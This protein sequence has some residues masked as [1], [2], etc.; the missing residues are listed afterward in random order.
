[1]SMLRRIGLGVLLL[2]VAWALVP[3][4][5][6]SSLKDNAT[7]KSPATVPAPGVATAPG[8]TA[9]VEPAPAEAG[10]MAYLDPETGEL[11]TGP[12]PS[13]ELEL[14]PDLKNALRRDDAGLEV[15]TRADGS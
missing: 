4:R 13:S 2:L 5:H 8:A 9:T 10:M 7:A 14:D 15:V 11:T 12:A 1:M 3:L 6:P